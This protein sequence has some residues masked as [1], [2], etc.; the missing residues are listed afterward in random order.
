MDLID[1]YRTFLRKTT[2]YTIFSSAYGTFSRIDH[3]LGHKSNLGKFK[4]IEIV[5]SIFSD[6]NAMRL[7]INYRKKS[8]KNTNTWRL[9][10][11]VLN[12]QGI[13][14]EIKEEI[15]KYLE[16]NDNENTTSQNLWGAAKAVLR[17]KF[18]A[19]QSYLNKQ[20][21][22]QI[23]NLNL[24]L[25]QLEKEEQKN[26]KVSRR[27]EIIKIR[28]EINEGASLVAQWLRI[29]LPMQRTQVRA[30]VWEDPTCRGTAGPVSHN[31]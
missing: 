24:H 22:M 7:D 4:K 27:K 30:L 1:I 2:E 3:I 8:V 20:E 28:S 10:N 13:T 15:K 17:G 16:L 14:E 31:Y 9:N 5:S 12:N 6:H 23:N 21:K 25:K 19:I 29:C 26:P 18:I 11:T